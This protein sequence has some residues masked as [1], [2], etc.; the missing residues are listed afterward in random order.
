VP[1]YCRYNDVGADQ[2]MKQ[3]V[4]D[5]HRRYIIIIPITSVDSHTASAFM[6]SY[7]AVIFLTQVSKIAYYMRPVRH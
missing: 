6:S 5:G 1:V 2:S 3:E 7:M 4:K